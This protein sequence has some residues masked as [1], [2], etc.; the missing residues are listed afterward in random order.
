MSI[1][2]I[3]LSAGKS[4]R[5]GQNKAL[6]P[7]QGKTL[8]EYQLHQLKQTTIVKIIV[9]LGFEAER[10]LPLIGKTARV[11]A[12]LN[13]AYATGKC[14]SIK[15]GMRALPARTE[16]VMILSIDQP[17][18]YHLLTEMIERHQSQA[19]LITAPTYSGKWGHPTIFSRQLFPELLEV[20]EEKEGLR[21]IM[22]G[23]REQVAEMVTTSPTVLVDL[24][25]PGDYEESLSLFSLEDIAAQEKQTETIHSYGAAKKG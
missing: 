5:M 23:Y 18:P 15:A 10:L 16:S 22:D 4:T 1:S 21:H 24:N 6:L 19:N 25:N 9:V 17:R 7:W 20:S 12:V 11:S 3:L 13:P 2:A 8:L 14:S